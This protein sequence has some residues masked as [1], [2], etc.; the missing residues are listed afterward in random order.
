MGVAGGE[1]GEEDATMELK[2][3]TFKVHITGTVNAWNDADAVARIHGLAGIYKD[4]AE[5][6]EIDTVAVP[7]VVEDGA[8]A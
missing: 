6:S 3:Y 8:D 2:L 1:S 7:E 5:W 4:G